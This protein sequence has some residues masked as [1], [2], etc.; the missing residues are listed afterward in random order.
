MPLQSGVLQSLR[1]SVRVG[2][3]LLPCPHDCGV[4][5]RCD[6]L[7]MGAVYMPCKSYSFHVAPQN[8]HLQYLVRPWVLTTRL[9]DLPLMSSSRSRKRWQAVQAIGTNDVTRA[10]GLTLSK[11]VDPSAC[12]LFGDS[13]TLA[14]RL[15]G[16]R[17]LLCLLICGFRSWSN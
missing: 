12:S 17:V 15:S 13:M 7:N 10:F 6:R 11:T 4:M 14:C 3:Q 5:W 1:R 8:P 9:H 2:L 16:W